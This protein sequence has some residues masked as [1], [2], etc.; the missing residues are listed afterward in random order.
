MYTLEQLEAY[1]AF[2][3]QQQ[4]HP[5]EPEQFLTVLMRDFALTRNEAERVY[6]AL[7]EWEMK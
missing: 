4:G 7:R 5:T 3:Q 1:Q 6:G 2:T